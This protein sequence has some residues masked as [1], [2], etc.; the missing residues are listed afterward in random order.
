MLVL[1]PLQGP[2]ELRL[3]S[4]H[5]SIGRH[6]EFCVIAAGHPW[7]E[8]VILTN[9]VGIHIIFEEKVNLY[10]ARQKLIPFKKGTSFCLVP[11][12]LYVILHWFPS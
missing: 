4:R 12:G 9:R 2:A 10:E 1:D 11:L 7:V 3:A 6:V 8:D 5:C